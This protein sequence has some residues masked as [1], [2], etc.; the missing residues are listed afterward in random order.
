MGPGKEFSGNRIFAENP[1]SG[2]AAA[3][4]RRTTFLQH[5]HGAIHRVVPLNDQ[6]LDK[7]YGRASGVIGRKWA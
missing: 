3:A 5:K 1:Y 7:V 4:Q 2:V 6:V